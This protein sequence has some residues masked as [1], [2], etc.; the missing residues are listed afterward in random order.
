MLRYENLLGKVAILV[1][2]MQ[3]DDN[4]FDDDEDEQEELDNENEVRVVVI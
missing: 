3:W 4:L 1:A 2:T